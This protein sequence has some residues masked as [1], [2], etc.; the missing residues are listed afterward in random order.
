MTKPSRKPE[1]CVDDADEADPLFA[2]VGV[3]IHF[4]AIRFL[5]DT[6]ESL[7]CSP[8]PRI[9]P[10]LPSVHP[11]SERTLPEDRGSTIYEDLNAPEKVKA[12]TSDIA[13][14]MKML[15]SEPDGATVHCV[16]ISELCCKLGRITVPP[17]LALACDGLSAP[18]PTTSNADSPNQVYSAEN[19]P[20]HWEHV[21]RIRGTNWRWNAKKGGEEGCMKELRAFMENGWKKIGKA[22]RWWEE[23]MGG[24]V[25][26]QR[27]EGMKVVNAIRVGVQN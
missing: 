22:E 6:S 5:T 25:E 3:G 10:I 13:A 4:P 23:A 24:V 12:S 18:P 14:L 9:S 20:P 1:R 21:K 16:S 11:L 19:P 26:D 8:Q 15:P 7:L 27:K 2:G 17:A